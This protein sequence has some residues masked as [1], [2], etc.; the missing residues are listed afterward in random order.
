MTIHNLVFKL[1]FSIQQ[2]I[3]RIRVLVCELFNVDATISINVTLTEQFFDNL[4]TM[5]LVDSLSLKELAH[6]YL[7]DQTI[8]I[9]ID[10]MM[11]PT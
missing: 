2:L 6:F 3:H 5:L 8:T 4:P 7:I 10:F 9:K 1:F 11:I